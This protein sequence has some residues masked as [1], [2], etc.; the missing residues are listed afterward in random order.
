M[1]MMQS[2]FWPMFADKPIHLISDCGF[3]SLLQ[4]TLT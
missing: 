4:R 1:R 3:V 2:Y